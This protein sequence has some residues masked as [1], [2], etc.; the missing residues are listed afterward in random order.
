MIIKQIP[1]DFIVKEISNVKLKDEGIFS[2]YRMKKK[3]YTSERAVQK[4]CDEFGIRRKFIGYAGN[5]DKKAITEQVIS[6]RIKR[7]V[8]LSLKDI[9]L[10]FLGF[11]DEPV[12]LG[13]LEGNEFIITVRDLGRVDLAVPDKIPN[14]FGEQRFSENNVKIGKLILKKDFKRAVEVIRDDKE[15]HDLICDYLER[16]KNDYIGALRL[17]P[18]KILRLYVH[19]VQS[20]IFNLT[21]REIINKKISDIKRVPIIGFGSEIEDERVEEIIDRL[22]SEERITYRDF[23][24]KEIP[25]LSSEGTERDVFMEVKDF[26]IIEKGDDELNEGKKK[27][28]LGFKLKKGSYATVVI[29]Q[30]F[31]GL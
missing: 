15:F 6:I 8:D 22:L 9:H 25:E 7:K 30:L 11:S 21:V 3:E 20:H 16:N 23:I 26:K 19:S 27:V 5:K 13:D 28:R 10:E 18:K 12:S 2:L 14:Y 17:I 29:K 31:K 4:I 24:I 1:E